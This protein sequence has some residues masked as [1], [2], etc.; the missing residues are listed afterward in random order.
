MMLTVDE[1]VEEDDDC[2]F[3]FKHAAWYFPFA[4]IATSVHA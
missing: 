3:A 2:V 4:V 1:I